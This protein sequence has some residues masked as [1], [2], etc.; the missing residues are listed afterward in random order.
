MTDAQ[1]ESG[2]TAE[3]AAFGADRR[4]L[5]AEL[6]GRPDASSLALRGGGGWLWSRAGR[7]ATQLG[8]LVAGT[9]A[10]AIA[11]CAAALDQLAG[12]VIIDV[13]D[14]EAGLTAFLRGRGFSL[15]RKLTRMALGGT[16][17][18]LG[19][20]MRAIAGPELG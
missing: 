4:P 2:A 1:A 15:E 16:P 20:A 5:L 19:P 3:A 9:E 10:G 6:R 11:L 8:P 17:V 12:P 14:R 18:T 13:P 7:T